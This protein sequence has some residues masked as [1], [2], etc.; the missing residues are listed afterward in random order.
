MINIPI[1]DSRA[2]V[3]R[4]VERICSELLSSAK[5]FTN[6]VR[7]MYFGKCIQYGKDTLMKALDEFKDKGWF[8]YYLVRFDG[9]IIQLQIYS[10]EY[11][12]RNDGLNKLYRRY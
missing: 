2:N 12:P 10:Y 11:Q 7:A 1:N 8:C 4:D 6:G 9:R 3:E 5:T